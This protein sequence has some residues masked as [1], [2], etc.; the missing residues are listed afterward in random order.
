MNLRGFDLSRQPLAPTAAL[1]GFLGALG[2]PAVQIPPDTDRQ[3]RLYRSLLADRR[4]LIVADN[5]R[6]A[7]QVRPLLPGTTG[8]LVLVTSRSQLSGLAVTDGANLIDLDLLTP[9]EARDLLA[10]RIGSGRV[11][12]EPQATEEIIA[13]CERLPLALAIAAARAAVRPTF[14]LHAIASELRGGR[15]DALSTGDDPASD[16]RAVFSWSYRTL[17]PAAARMFR[18]LG[19]HPGPDISSLAAAS[20][21]GFP[22]KPD[23]LAPG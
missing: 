4:M 11:A 3:A 7:P 9:T 2:V 6:D 8:C 15:L 20:L 14:P 21:V 18:L 12:A 5:A 22:G 10:A 1:R 13:R 17:T 16:A 19:L 23:A